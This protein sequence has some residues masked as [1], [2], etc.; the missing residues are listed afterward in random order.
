[1]QLR[2]AFIAE[3]REKGF[4][5]RANGKYKHPD[6]PYKVFAREAV[7]ILLGHKPSPLAPRTTRPAI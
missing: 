3:I 6:V 2:E 5:R 1:M 4:E 7:A